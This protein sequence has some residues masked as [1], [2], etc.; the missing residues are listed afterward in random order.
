MSESRSIVSP[1]AARYSKKHA[2]STRQIDITYIPVDSFTELTTQPGNFVLAAISYGAKSLE[3]KNAKFP[4]FQ[5]EIEQIGERPVIEVWSS[6]SQACYGTH[7]GIS[8]SQDGEFLVGS[9]STLETSSSKLET[10]TKKAYEIITKFVMSRGYNHF[11]RVWNYFPSIN[12]EE[13]G[14]ER[15]KTFCTGR[16]VAFRSKYIKDKQQHFPAASA[17]GTKGNYL[18]ICF[19]ASKTPGLNIE[20]PRQISAYNYPPK[21]GAQSPSFSRASYHTSF[22]EDRLFIAGTASIVGHETKHVRNFEKQL[23]ETLNNISTLLKHAKKI[24]CTGFGSPS[25]LSLAKIYI[26]DKRNVDFAHSILGKFFGLKVK[27]IFL[28]ADICRRDLLLEVECIGIK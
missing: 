19:I 10:I 9:I 21:Y 14:L 25:S 2:L 23:G 15:Y 12:V 16:A 26:R 7:N 5:V 11:L 28:Q 24:G 6:S 17:V 22:H 3:A 20:N 8:Y 4:I 13:N 1:D 27:T 18:T